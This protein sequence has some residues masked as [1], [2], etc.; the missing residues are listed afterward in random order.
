MVSAMLGPRRIGRLFPALPPFRPPDAALTDLGEAMVDSLPQ[1]PEGDSRIPAGF[2]YLGQFIDHDLTFDPTVGFPG[3]HDPDTIEDGRTPAF[4]LDGVYGL[5]PVRQPELYDP[6]HPPGRAHLRV[7]LTDPEPATGGRGVPDIPGSLPHDLPRHPD[8]AAIIPDGR[9]DENLLLAQTHLALLQFHNRVIDTLPHGPAD[10]DRHAVFSKAEEDEKG[11]AFHRATR[12]VRWHYQ[13]IVLHDL[14]PR[15]ADPDVVE[16]VLRNGRRFFRF[17]HGAVFVPVEFSVAA[18]RLG[19]SMVRDAYD[20]NRVF[21][22]GG[23]PALS[24]ATFELLFALTGKGGFPPP[25]RCALPS[26]WIVDWRRFHEVGR[27]E[28][29][30]FA[31]RLDTRITGGL[32]DLAIPGVVGVPPRALPVRALLRGSGVGLP[33]GQDV[34]RAMD[35]RPLTPDEIASGPV[36]GPVLR[37]HRL[38]LGTPLWY[39]VLKEAEVRGGGQRLGEVGSR[40]L[41]EVFV[42]LLEGDRNSFL[43]KD[44]RWRPTVPA[45]VPGTFTFA[46]LLRFTG[47][48]NPLGPG[49]E[50]A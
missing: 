27:P 4:D 26:N 37:A 44:R 46:D 17:E 8:R 36:D 5:G 21:N 49:R 50:G 43:A 10:D 34:A 39:Y 18:Y 20:F 45:A 47:E 30:N 33:S 1:T 15:I 3:I 41:A 35:A 9:D 29:L 32:H 7:G 16:D 25:T 23:G 31:R 14:L 2:T 22:G 6:A 12:L 28:L 40:I 48:I 13:W 19:H 11:T 42:G 24:S 38:H